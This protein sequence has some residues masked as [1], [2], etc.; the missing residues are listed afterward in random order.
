MWWWMSTAISVSP[1]PMQGGVTPWTL[2]FRGAALGIHFHVFPVLV[3]FQTHDVSM[4]CPPGAPAYIVEGVVGS[5]RRSSS[6][7]SPLIPAM[8]GWAKDTGA[9]ASV[10]VPS[11]TAWSMSP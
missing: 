7:P 6:N 2:P 5:A 4:L 8:V 3:V 10:T 9:A 11:L 1:P